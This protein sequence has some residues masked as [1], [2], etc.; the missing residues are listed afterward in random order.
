MIV[1]E[2]PKDEVSVSMELQELQSPMLLACDRRNAES[3]DIETVDIFGG[4]EPDEISL[5]ENRRS[6]GQSNKPNWVSKSSTTRKSNECTTERPQLVGWDDIKCRPIYHVFK[7]KSSRKKVE[8]SPDEVASNSCLGEIANT[9]TRPQKKRVYASTFRKSG[10][11]KAARHN[12]D[13]DS[14]SSS[15]VRRVTMESEV[16]NGEANRFFDASNDQED[17]SEFNYIFDLE[18]NHSDCNQGKLFGTQESTPISESKIENRTQPTSK[19]TIKSARAFFSYL[20]SNHRLNIIRNEEETAEHKRTA[21]T[22]IRT[23]RR[24]RHCNQLRD[25]YNEYS[26]MGNATGI[27]PISLEEFARHWNTYFTERGIIRDG[28]LDED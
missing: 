27:D 14:P 18:F 28:L 16:E 3:F 21:R 24:I 25:E 10:I 9:Q 12:M 13:L 11:F 2:E 22:V 4:L 17:D 7:P 6:Y 8:S 19:S 5:K 23:T 26:K 20:D 15:V 1:R